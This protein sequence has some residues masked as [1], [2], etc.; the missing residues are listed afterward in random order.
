MA[1]LHL[2]EA[3]VARAAMLIRRPVDV[4]FTAFVDPAFTTRFW[5]SRSSGRLEA[6]KQICWDWEM[7]GHSV[8]VDVLA[9]EANRRILIAWGGYGT[10]TTVEW[11]FTA[12]PDGTTFVSITNA[13]FSGEGDAVAHQALD[14]TE[15][16]TLVLVGA[17]ALLEHNIELR[18]VPDR[19]PD[20]HV[21]STNAGED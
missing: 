11:A 3:P 16:F 14:S 1:D 17:K 18:L 2:S 5:F 8:T 15:G 19:F 13:G 9:I 10:M 20:Q 12:R 4:V 7:Y 6:G 21:H